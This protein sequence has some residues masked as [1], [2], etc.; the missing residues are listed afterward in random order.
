MRTTILIVTAAFLLSDFRVASAWNDTGHMTVALIAYRQLNDQQ[1]QRVA[2]ILRKHP[3]Y[4]LYLSARRP[5][6]A[7]EDEW[8]FLRGATWSDFVR[9]ARPGRGA[10]SAPSAEVELF[11]GPEITR[12]DH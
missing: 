9:P 3:H 7:S 12:F 8:A 2:D 4:E 11:K 6:A 1:R 10:A 5:P